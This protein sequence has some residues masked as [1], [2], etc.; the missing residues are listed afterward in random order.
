MLPVERTELEFDRPLL[1]LAARTD[2]WVFKTPRMT[3]MGQEKM[4]NLLSPSADQVTIGID[5][6][7][8]QL[9][10]HTHPGGSIQQ[11]TNDHTGH[12][13]LI[14]WITP[15]QP[16]RIIFE[17]TGAYHRG[18][19]SALAKAALPWVKINPWQARRFAEATGRRVKTDSVDA[20]MLA[21]FGA[22]LQPDPTPARE[23]I[24]DS[25]AELLAARRALVKDRTAALNRGK[26]L[27]LPLLKR[28]NQYHLKQIEVQINDIDREQAT[29]VAKQQSLKARFDILL[30]I[31]GLGAVSVLAML[32]DMPELGSLEARQAASL[33]GLAPITRQSGN[34]QGKSR[35]QGGRAPLRQAL[36]M[37]ALVAIRFNPPLKAKYLALRAAG[38]PAKVAIVAIMRKLL[39]LAN[40]LLRDQR[41]WT[42]ERAG[43]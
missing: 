5:I 10:V 13:R 29:L 32:I 27:T 28:H 31:P 36:Y 20:A 37:P 42:P 25:L 40:A 3:S 18:L 39:I 35:I 26:N 7:K 38:K 19:Q 21:R 34:C 4:S 24:A 16:A 12:A 6:S 43:A 30:S 11:F 33:G 9:D 14:A 1:F 17:A 15:R 22:T 2:T 41:M 23:P 8:H